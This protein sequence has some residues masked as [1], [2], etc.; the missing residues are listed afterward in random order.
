[1]GE[2]S[3]LDR[4]FEAFKN[5]RIEN[6]VNDFFY[7]LGQ[8]RRTLTAEAWKTFINDCRAHPVMGIFQQDPFTRRCYQKPRG[9]PGDPVVMDLIYNEDPELIASLK[10]ESDLGLRIYREFLK[11]PETSAV[12]S[13][14]AIL[15][16]KIDETLQRCPSPAIMSVGCGHLREAEACQGMRDHQAVRFTAIDQDTA[17]LE[18]VRKTWNGRIGTASTSVVDIL[19]KDTIRD[20][21]F[22]LIYAAG[23]YDYLN[24][25]LSERLTAAL[26]GKLRSGG[27]LLIA[28]FIAEPPNVAFME[29]CMDWWLIYRVEEDMIRMTA[30]IDRKKLAELRLYTDDTGCIMFLEL[31]SQ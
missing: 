11:H 20:T 30:R 19:R 4:T 1:M 2:R 25:N 16:S 31:T 10:Q 27:K 5:D 13:R 3:L 29:A 15:T 22:D 23:L 24:D 14:K 18:V 17:S 12:R 9:Y 21:G 7:G 6:V 8:I 28:N 26:F